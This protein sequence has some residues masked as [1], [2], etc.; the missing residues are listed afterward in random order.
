A[1]WYLRVT[2]VL[3]LLLERP[4]KLSTE[5]RALLAT[6]LHQ[7]EYSRNPLHATVDAAVDAARV[8]RQ[9]R[10]AG[11][12]NGVLRRFTREK[13][14]LLKRVDES[15]AVRTAHPQWL[16]DEIQAAWP[17][18]AESVLNAN[19]GHPPMV[20]RVDL[21]RTGVNDFIAELAKT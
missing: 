11:L 7:I 17:E 2:A 8:L 13:E 19:N 15:L 1:R 14:A 16:V 3:D 12:V 21:S 20:V 9:E 10:A 18:R 6:A 5:V 4:E